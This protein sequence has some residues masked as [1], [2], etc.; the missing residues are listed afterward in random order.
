MRAGSASLN[1]HGVT[2]SGPGVSGQG[3]GFGWFFIRLLVELNANQVS[4]FAD[5][6]H[7]VF[8]PE[9]LIQNGWFKLYLDQQQYAFLNSQS[10]LVALYPVK[11]Y[12]KPNFEELKGLSEYQVE[13]T[14]DWQP[15]PPIEA[16]KSQRGFYLVKGAS[17]A[18]IF[19]D[20]KVVSVSKPPKFSFK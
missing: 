4:N 17:P 2:I 8:K 10:N 19:E 14:E 15:K 18:E 12:V 3:A 5:T 9:N 16:R 7:I 20:P 13:A 6:G 1:I 11:Q